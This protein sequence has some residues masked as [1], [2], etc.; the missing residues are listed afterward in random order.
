[1][2][3]MMMMTM[4]MTMMMMMMG[5]HWFNP[6]NLLFPFAPLTVRPP[7]PCRGI[8]YMY[9]HVICLLRVCERYH[10]LGLLQ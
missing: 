6:V 3:M 5:T 1:M 7:L 8:Y 4:M 10:G 2:M 9:I